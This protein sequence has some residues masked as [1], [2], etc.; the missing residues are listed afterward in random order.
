M[1]CCH[2]LQQ[3][4]VCLGA[5][6]GLVV[7]PDER[8]AGHGTRLMHELCSALGA[9]GIPR[10]VALTL[11]Q[12]PPPPGPK[13]LKHSQEEAQQV[14]EGL[15]HDGPS[16]PGP[17]LLKRKLGFKPL[18]V[19]GSWHTT[20]LLGIPHCCHQAHQALRTNHRMPAGS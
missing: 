11:P 3:S 6:Q 2:H 1:E 4:L 20:T 9:A 17:R 12:D 7:L 13:Q 16:G 19:G 18:Q 14:E 10:M 8:R 5:V 15:F